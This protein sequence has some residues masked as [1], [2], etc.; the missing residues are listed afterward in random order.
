VRSW[1]IPYRT[2]DGM[3]RYAYLLL[4]AWYGSAVHP[5]IPLVISP[6]GRG[7]GARANARLWGGLPA[8]GRF[9]VV[10]PGGQGRRLELFSWGYRGQIEDLARMPRILTR[11]LPW[12]RIDRRRIYAAGGSM[13]AQEA[14]LLAA[15]HPH[16]L[17]GV[18]AFDAAVDLSARYYA[19]PRIRCRASCLR[20][21]G[22]PVGRRLQAL[23]RS[24]VGGTPRRRRFAYAARSPIT[25]TRALARS[26]I[27]LQ[28]W[29]SVADG[30]VVDGRRE[31]GRLYRSILRRN[32]TAP[33][34]AFIGRWHHSRGM[35]YSSKLRVALA[36]FGLL[37][38]ADVAGICGMKRG[39]R[40]KLLRPHPR[41]PVPFACLMFE[42]KPTPR[43][44][45]A[46]KPPP[47][48]SP[49]PPQ[50]A[51]W[52]D[53]EPQPYEPGLGEIPTSSPASVTG[54]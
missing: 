12:L 37:K 33:V 44:R 14:L 3:R 54:A 30:I 20:H 4:P 6:H 16:V 25:Y 17:A 39:P 13:G 1:R 22:E 43:R 26:G 28:L 49:P 42:A 7:V 5:A 53:P 32:P 8:L 9:A 48:P 18:I 29:W 19:F 45:S 35:R 34:A 15:R 23:A 50:A 31:S 11:A 47:D 51:P 52:P 27:P 36:R 21:W 2:N 38:P 24:E 40:G 46:P 10:N 41:A